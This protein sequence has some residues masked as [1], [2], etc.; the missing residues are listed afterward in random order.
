M[1]FN[2]IVLLKILSVQVTTLIARFFLITG[3][4]F[5]FKLFFKRLFKIYLRD[6]FKQFSVKINSVILICNNFNT[7]NYCQYKYFW[8]YLV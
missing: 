5:K 1:Y 2:L 8:V 3:N 6:Y 7:G 4:T